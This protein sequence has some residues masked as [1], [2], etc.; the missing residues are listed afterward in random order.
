MT[1]SS[2]NYMHSE[3]FSRAIQLYAEKHLDFE[4]ELAQYSSFGYVYASPQCIIIAVQQEDC[5]FIQFAIGEGYMRRFLELM[6]FEL[7]YVAWERGLKSGKKVRVKLS[8]LR[9]HL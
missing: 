7:P 9:R 6:P 5:W 3:I 4:K 8:T 2:S 1:C